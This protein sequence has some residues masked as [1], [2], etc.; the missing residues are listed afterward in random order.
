[1]NSKNVVA[2][3]REYMCCCCRAMLM[4]TE[5]FLYAL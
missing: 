1:M 4:E 3:G 2:M 5:C